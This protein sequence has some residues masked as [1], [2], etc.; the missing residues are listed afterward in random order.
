MDSKEDI[1]NRLNYLAQEINRGWI[2]YGRYMDSGNTLN[3]EAIEVR[4]IIRGLEEEK[5]KLQ[6]MDNSEVVHYINKHRGT[7][8][9]SGQQV[10]PLS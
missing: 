4:D 3:P 8:D 7:N 5:S 1:K 6:L 10:L 9:T 2:L